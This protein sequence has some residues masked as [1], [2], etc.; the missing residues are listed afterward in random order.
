M[1]RDKLIAELKEKYLDDSSRKW[2]KEN[3]MYNFSIEEIADEILADRSRVLGEIKEKIQ[4]AIVDYDNHAIHASFPL[5]GDYRCIEAEKNHIKGKN[6]GLQFALA[7]IEEMMKGVDMR[8]LKFRA[9]DK[10]KQKM[11]LFDEIR[12]NNEYNLLG[13]HEKSCSDYGE[14]DI[15][16]ENYDLMQFT[17]LLDKNGKEIWEGDIVINKYLNQNIVNKVIFNS[18][19]FYIDNNERPRLLG[20]F[21]SDKDLVCYDLEIIGNIYE[22]PELLKG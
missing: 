13:F 15:D 11:Y 19:S 8:E 14:L 6:C 12:I 9:W 16:E 10:T 21:I 5:D 7:K 2:H 3:S 20:E 17:G 4:M 1:E 18:A 22:N